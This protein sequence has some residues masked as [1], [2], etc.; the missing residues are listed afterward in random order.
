MRC[1]VCKV[2]MIIVEHER[3]ELD[4]CTK[5]LGVWFDA[6][7]LELLLE[8]AGMDSAEFNMQK[9][10]SLP[11]KK[12]KE[13][14]RRCSLCGKK[15]RKVAIGSSP[16]VVIDAC[17]FGEGLWF[18]GGEVGQV[19]QQLLDKPSTSAMAEDRMISF[20]GETFKSR[21]NK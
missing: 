17:V 19:I 1:P 16:E 12:I 6:G 10:L 18:D 5:C 21:G 14:A 13:S 8:S 9:I 11:E 3:I 7:E 2:P 4:Y 15:M 20:L